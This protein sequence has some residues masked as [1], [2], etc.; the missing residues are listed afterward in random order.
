MA[1]AEAV[2]TSDPGNGWQ[3]LLWLRAPRQVVILIY[4]DDRR[5]IE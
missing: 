2:A 4:P 5:L 1:I 3:L